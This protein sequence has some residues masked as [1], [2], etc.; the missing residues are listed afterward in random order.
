MAVLAV[1][2]ACLQFLI[3]PASRVLE[4]QRRPIILR[5]VCFGRYQ[6]DVHNL[7]GPKSDKTSEMVGGVQVASV[8]RVY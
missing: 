1:T 6:C 8:I 5:P 2:I 4:Q 7:C 3:L